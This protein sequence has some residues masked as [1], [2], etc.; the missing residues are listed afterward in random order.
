MCKFL[1][2]ENKE[3]EIIPLCSIND[4]KCPYAI[5]CNHIKDIKLKYNWKNCNLYVG[6]WKG[7]IIVS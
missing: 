3:D 4:K 6:Y 2:K 5:F 7:K 1:K